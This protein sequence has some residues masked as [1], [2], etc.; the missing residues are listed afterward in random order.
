MF[1]GWGP[2]PTA[3]RTTTAYALEWQ[4]ADLQ[5]SEENCSIC[6]DALKESPIVG[7]SLQGKEDLHHLFHRSCIQQWNQ[8]S[9]PV[10]RA[11]IAPL[12]EKPKTNQT[13]ISIAQ[14]ILLNTGI[15]FLM[16]FA[17]TALFVCINHSLHPT[18]RLPLCSMKHY[19]EGVIAGFALGSISWGVFGDGIFFTGRKISQYPLCENFFALET[20]KCLM[21]MTA[22]FTVAK[23]WFAGWSYFL[24]QN[25]Q[26]VL[27]SL[28]G[29]TSP[30]L[31]AKNAVAY[32][33]LDGFT[34]G[35]VH[36]FGMLLLAKLDLITRR[37]PLDGWF[38]PPV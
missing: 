31:R 4:G 13:V 28:R 22:A 29:Q 34:S 30:L 14:N 2:I 26:V 17:S 32:Q 9:C 33:R 18:K 36:V 24:A 8:P 35:T 38:F 6:L 20:F 23:V 10:C 3:P 5:S 12:P 27:R 1:I 7:H 37:K 15:Y 11:Y 16:A 21:P 25:T 19:A